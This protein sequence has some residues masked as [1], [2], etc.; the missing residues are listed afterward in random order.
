MLG[1]DVTLMHHAVVEGRTDIGAGCRVFPMAII[2]G[3]PQS[4]RHDGSL[5]TLKVGKNCTMREGVT[6]NT[7]SSHG[8]GKTVVGDNNLFLANSH[9]G[10]DCVIGSNV[11]LSNNVMVGGHAIIDDRVIL[12]GGAAIHQFV[13]VGRQA[14][15][16]GLAGV[17]NDIIPYAMV[18]DNPAFMGGL[19]V[20]GMTRSGMSRSEL[21]IV[22]KAYKAIFADGRVR[23]N[24]SAARDAFAGQS[25]A[26]LEIIDF[27]LNR[28]GE[29]ALTT[30]GS[31][32][33]GGETG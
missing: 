22:R 20:V 18:V 33:R 28:E 8:G 26:A 12:S 13:H 19:N 27:V 24:A 17:V 2:G 11:V 5:T 14:F 21:H 29:R 25:D 31:R 10:H 15:V 16:G 4:I 23:E 32:R 6:I 30:P 7:G 1:D 9:V 3:E